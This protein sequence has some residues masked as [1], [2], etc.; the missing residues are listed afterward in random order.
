MLALA[1][2]TKEARVWVM[3][4]IPGSRQFGL[5]LAIE[6]RVSKSA[7]TQNKPEHGVVNYRLAATFIEGADLV[8]QFLDGEGHGRVPLLGLG[9]RG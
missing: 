9:C 4:D 6:I 8:V 2:A 5:E 7:T 1:V 3:A